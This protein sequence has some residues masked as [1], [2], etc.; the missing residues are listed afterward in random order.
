MK[1]GTKL[2][3]FFS[4]I[5]IVPISVMGLVTRY[6]ATEALEQQALSQLV[7]LREAKKQ[8]ISDYFQ[9]IQ[10]QVT[11]FSED[12]MTIQASPTWNCEPTMSWTPEG[13]S[14]RAPAT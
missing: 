8:Q 12:R 14:R 11:T 7:S 1:L 13:D 10:K 3:I 2:I 9:F 6:Y 5:G 4:L